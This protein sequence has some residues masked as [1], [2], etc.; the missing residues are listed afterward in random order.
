VTPSGVG[1]VAGSSAARLRV[2]T[3]AD[4]LRAAH[5][6]ALVVSVSLKDR[7]A[8]L[9]AGKHPSHVLWFDPALDTFVTSTAFEQA[10]PAW[11]ARFGDARAVSAARSIPWEL[12]DREWVA[13]HAAGPD[14]QPGEGDLDG[15]GTTFPH[16]ARTAASFRALP[17]ADGA[18]VDL[19]LAALDAEYDPGRPTLLLLSLS[20]S[21]VI[22]HVFGPDSWE[23]WDHLRKLDKRLAALLDT[24]D[25]RFGNV[26]VLLAGDHGNLSMPEIAPVRA[27][28]SCPTPERPSPPPDPFG[29]PCTPGVRV[30]AN[31]LERELAA[32]AAHALGEGRWVAGIADPYLFLTAEAR[33]L[34]TGRR[35]RLDQAVR[36][37]F[38]K[39]P[40]GVEQLLDTR[41]LAEQCPR[42]LAEAKGVPERARAGED[43]LTLV[44][45]S[46]AP[47]AAAG[48]YYV[49][50]RLGSSF[51]GEIVRGK[52]ASHGS[53]AVYDRTVSMLVRAPGLVDA[54][55]VI[56]EPVDFSAFSA[57]VAAFVGLDAR[58]PRDILRAHVAK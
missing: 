25:R 2:D 19:A 29:R 18:V 43:V 49:V 13:A 31:V 36:A 22:G 40:D 54:N 45:R 23:A 30:E 12:G 15:L 35:A 55:A 11:A 7:A 6:E 9:P 39:H 57:L 28:V 44:C 24:V 14:D 41:M 52:G 47:V 48:D 27:G 17:A 1:A 46:W 53:P 58:E 10:F 8:I 33:A 21:D 20:A 3:V 5:P 56:D 50:P 37:T 38:A 4:R 51:D 26:P 32:A 16:V 34:G 42:V